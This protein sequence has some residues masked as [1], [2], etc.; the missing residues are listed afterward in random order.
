MAQ[1][2]TEL[3]NFWFTQVS[4]ERWFREDDD[5]LQAQVRGEV[6]SFYD[7][8]VAGELKTWART[9]EGMLGLLLL[10]GEWPRRLF[11]GTPQAYAT[12]DEALELARAGI[13]AHLD[14]RIDRMFK[15]FFYRP[16]GHAENIGDQRLSVFYVRERTK[17]PAWIDAAQQRLELIERFGRF[18]YRNA[19]LGREST[20]D[21]LAW[22]KENPTG[23]PLPTSSLTSSSAGI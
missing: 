5:E 23:L 13:L 22:L 21:E 6:G 19:I 17:E 7:Q 8:A 10:L 12:D 11:R 4:P 1:D 9:P 20:P 14:D 15:M 16:F 2:L 3:L 18:P